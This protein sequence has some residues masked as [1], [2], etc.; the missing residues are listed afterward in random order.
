VREGEEYASLLKEI[1]A[2][3]DYSMKHFSGS[4]KYTLIQALIT[5]MVD[6]DFDEALKLFEAVLAHDP[7]NFHAHMWLGGGIYKRKLM[8]KEALAHLSKVTKIDP[9]YSSAW[10]EI[11]IVFA[12]MGDYI[13]AEKAYHHA[14]IL[15]AASNQDAG[16]F[17]VQGKTRPG[18]KEEDPIRYFVD[19]KMAER[20]FRGI[21]AML[22]T[23]AAI[24]P[25]TIAAVKAQSYYGL[26][27]QDSVNHY[28][29]L[30]LDSTDGF[31]PFIN[32]LLGNKEVALRNRQKSVKEVKDLMVTC[33]TKVQEIV[34]LSILGE[35]EEATE[36]LVT[37]NRQYP[38]FGGYARLFNDPMLDRIKSESPAFVE[39][40]NNLKLPPKLDLDGLIKF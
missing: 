7:E 35:Y 28:G 8:Q 13:S 10:S 15:G 37:M 14:T 2:L 4:P 26:G 38:S 34:L 32:A 21:I 30:Y 40:L 29:Q 27:I 12:T 23:A 19:T 6:L 16:I 22:D 25:L 24:H 36:L 17:F 11:T 3:E 31:N 20:D 39:A 9:S 33:G 1:A 5:Y 18:L